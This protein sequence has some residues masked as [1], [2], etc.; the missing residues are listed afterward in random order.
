MEDTS[1]S[2]VRLPPASLSL[3]SAD[4]PP[5]PSQGDIPPPGEELSEAE[6]SVFLDGGLFSDALAQAA[7]LMGIHSAAD[8]VEASTAPATTTR[9]VQD[10]SHDPVAGP[11]EELSHLPEEA[12]PAT[13]PATA[14]A[15]EGEESASDSSLVSDDSSSALDQRALRRTPPAAKHGEPSLGHLAAGILAM[16]NPDRISTLVES[17]SSASA[18]L[19]GPGGSASVGPLPSGGHGGPWMRLDSSGDLVSEAEEGSVTS[20]SSDGGVGDLRC[21]PAA[22]GVDPRGGGGGSAGRDSA[23]PLRQG[24]VQLTASRMGAA[25]STSSGL[26]APLAEEGPYEDREGAVGKGPFSAFAMA[27]EGLHEQ[28]DGNLADGMR[29]R[30]GSLSSVD[31]STLDPVGPHD[32]S[33]WDLD[34]AGA[35][36]VS[37]VSSSARCGGAGKPPPAKGRP[38]R[39]LNGGAR[40]AFPPLQLPTAPGAAHPGASTSSL[41]LTLACRASSSASPGGGGINPSEGLTEEFSLGSL[42]LASPPPSASARKAAPFP[43]ACLVSDLEGGFDLSLSPGIANAAAYKPPLPSTSSP[44]ML[45]AAAAAADD[46][47]VADP[48]QALGFNLRRGGIGSPSA[49]GNKTQGSVRSSA[50]SPGEG[51]KTFSSHGSHHASPSPSPASP[52]LRVRTRSGSRS[53]NG[54]PS[55]L[56]LEG[57]PTAADGSTLALGSRPSSDP[58]QVRYGE[59]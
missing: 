56:I 45:D 43:H 32:F 31:S 4:A 20:H 18:S 13:S 58:F 22:H 6:T 7:V 42:A 5:A 2:D 8:D 19:V 26:M 38:S 28:L 23:K 52:N 29:C 34:Q 11:K 33:Y 9:Q 3:P 16:V 12:P 53:F 37:D 39:S 47:V 24:G 21:A 10:E 46:A 44:L 36:A 30:Q 49:V 25:A 55:S 40:K 27:G 1:V 15:Y 41:A 14:D 57:A 35:G 54:L 17:I 48:W 59:K 51:R 50:S